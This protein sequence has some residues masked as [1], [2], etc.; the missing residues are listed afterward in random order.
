MIKAF[1]KM[2]SEFSSAK[3]QTA[4]LTFIRFLTVFLTTSIMFPTMVAYAFIPMDTSLPQFLDAVQIS[5]EFFGGLVLK[6]LFCMGTLVR[7]FIQG[8]FAL[9]VKFQLHF[10][11]L[12]M[13]F[14]L[15]H[16]MALHIVI[17]NARSF[18]DLFIALIHDGA[19]AL[20]ILY[21]DSKNATKAI[22]R[23]LC[24]DGGFLG[25]LVGLGV[26]LILLPWGGAALL[27]STAHTLTGGAGIVDGL[28]AGMAGSGSPADILNQTLKAVEEAS[29][30]LFG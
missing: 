24:K 27:R 25:N 22:Y 20:S 17:T 9:L 26:L 8:V 11:N 13:A 30:R 2:L 3:L 6:T 12:H 10:V 23:E 29:E 16:F 21:D 19:L 14:T 1:T 18:I 4:L 5:Y 28:G 7:D 15:A